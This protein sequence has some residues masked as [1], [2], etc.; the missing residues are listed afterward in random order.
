VRVADGQ[1]IAIGGLLQELETR[2]KNKIPLLGD[3]PL[4]GPIFRSTTTDISEREI[5]I[6]VVPHILD[7]TG[8]FKGPLL[9]ERIDEAGSK[10]ATQVAASTAKPTTDPQRTAQPHW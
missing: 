9:F 8:A 4:V 5:T 3:L 1:V 6:F 2:T 7:E 10:T